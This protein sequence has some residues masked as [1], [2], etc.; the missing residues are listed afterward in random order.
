MNAQMTDIEIPFAKDRNKRYRFF[1]ALPG[2]VSWSMLAL[3]F[4]L[5]LINV[6]VAAVFVLVYLLVN[7]C[8]AIAGGLRA[9]QGFRIVGKHQKFD[10]LSMLAELE[11]GNT[12]D[13]HGRFPR[14]HYEAMK[15]YWQQRESL[16]PAE[17]HVLPSEVIH[18]IIIATYK[19]SRE[20]LEPTIQSVLAGEYDM[21]KVVLILAYEGRA[22]EETAQRSKE[23]VSEY[24]DQFMDAFAVEHPSNLPGE[25]IGKGGN[26]TFAARELHKYL[27][28]HKIDPIRVLVTTLDADNRPHKKYLAALSYVYTVAPDPIHASYQPVSLYTNNIWDVPAP[29]RVLATGNSFFNVVASLRQHALRNFSSHAQPMAALI[30]TDYWSVRTIVEDGHQFWR[31]YFAFDGNYRVYPLY[32]PIYQD[33]VLSDSYRKTLKAQFVQLRRWTYGASDVAYV[34]DKGFFSKN[35]VPLPDLIAKTWRLFEGHVTWASGP[36]LVLLGG[37][38][39][40]L[41]APDNISALQLPIIVSR[42]QQFAMVGLIISIF[43]SLLTLPPKPARYRRH[44]TIYMVLQWVYLPVTTVVYNSFA[45]YYSQTRLMFGKYI[46]KF[47]VTEKAVMGDDKKATS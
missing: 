35:K 14:W 2:I 47:D 21:K 39:P 26:V 16:K 43:F 23:L 42:I 13:H 12:P 24:K 31:S 40:A 10:W 32:V 37:F 27:V 1:E 44:R 41:F 9:L 28:K 22:G 20:I 5:S 30:E 25:I 34:V 8:R 6:Q 19:E 4:V 46:D 45:A 17:R 38:I 15:R 18:A 36:F 3:P 11:T 7:F 29:M 33:A